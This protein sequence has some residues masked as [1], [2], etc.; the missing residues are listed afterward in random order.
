MSWKTTIVEITTITIIKTTKTTK[1]TTITKTTTTTTTTIT[2]NNKILQ[3]QLMETKEFV[4]TRKKVATK[5]VLAGFVATF[6]II[7][8]IK[9]LFSFK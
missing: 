6:M 4:S 5:S 1:I 7:K 3:T 9:K 2:T 8:V